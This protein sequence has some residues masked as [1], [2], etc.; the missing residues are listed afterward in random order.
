[1]QITDNSLKMLVKYEE[2]RRIPDT[3]YAYSY[4]LQMRGDYRPC[5]ATDCP[6][7]GRIEGRYRN[8]CRL[9]MKQTGRD[10]TVVLNVQSG[11]A[12]GYEWT[13][14]GYFHNGSKSVS[15]KGWR[16][17]LLAAARAWTKCYAW[18]VV[19]RC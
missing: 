15:P 18:L 14:F 12:D 17:R 19:N 5:S 10:R 4:K 16:D 9:L 1:M 3:V 6:Y 11:C 8:N 2:A 13:P 7:G